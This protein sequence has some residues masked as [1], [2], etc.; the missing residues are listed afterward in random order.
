MRRKAPRAHSDISEVGRAPAAR[1]ETARPAPF[2]A[3]VAV[4][5]CNPKGRKVSAVRGHAL[6]IAAAVLWGGWVL[7]LRPA[8]LEGSMA[9]LIALFVMSL[10]SPFF[11]PRIRQADRAA[12]WAL[13]SLGVADALNAAL[14]FSALRRGPIAV[15]VLT[16]YLGPLLVALL[17]PWVLGEPR[18]KRVLIAGPMVLLGLALVVRPAS[19]ILSSSTLITAGLGSASALFFAAT[20]LSA[21]RAGRA[22]APLAV[23]SLHSPIS[24]LVLVLV[25]GGEAVPTTLSP[26][27]L[28]AAA[29]G[30][31]C[32]LFANTLFNMG[33]RH[34]R[35]QAAS[36]LIYLE[37]ISAAVLGVLVFGESI[38]W[39]GLVGGALA[40]AAG[41]WVALEPDR[42]PGTQVVVNV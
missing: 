24:V 23:T 20:I 12:V 1:S 42:T 5:A 35:A 8:G 28:T 3:A 30:A 32:G 11:L 39:L 6:V 34:I 10:P 31:V 41:V 4:L 26:Q 13:I 27:V 17:A 16:H 2:K 33:L 7:F 38:G 21:K 29:G 14:F 36:V 18:S 37:P 25:S 15:A 9:A 40:V 22:F 19:G